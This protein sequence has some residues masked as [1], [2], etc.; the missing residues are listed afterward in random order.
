MEFRTRLLAALCFLSASSFAMVACDGAS[1]GGVNDGQ[2]S[3]TL[4]NGVDDD[5]DG[6]VD[7]A[8]EGA[9]SAPAD[10]NGE[11]APVAPTADAGLV[12]DEE[13]DDEDDEIDEDD[14]EVL[15]DA[16]VA[17]EADAGLLPIDEDDDDDDDEESVF[18]GFP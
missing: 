1:G 7:E 11:S 13:L 10:P 9:T 4:N 5:G 2:G 12:D 15:G 8:G 17:P 6:K 18:P 3:S 16:S 14:D